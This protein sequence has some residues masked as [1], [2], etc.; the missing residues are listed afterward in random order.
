FLIA[1]GIGVVP[2]SFLAQRC[3]EEN[4]G[5][6]IICYIGAVNSEALAGLE[7][8]EEVCSAVEISTDD[9]SRGYRGP[10]TGLFQRDMDRYAG[11]DVRIYACGP[12]PMFVHLQGLLKGRSC[13]CQVSLDE[14]MACG[15]GA[16]LGC[17]V[18]VRG[19]GSELVRVCTEG[20]VFDIRDVEFGE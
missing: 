15:I 14:R 16:C 6:E 12:R 1:G 11:D 2:L 3:A 5:T 9:G 19:N 20:P 4:R 18:R 17:A 8:F 13:V 10:V 7:R